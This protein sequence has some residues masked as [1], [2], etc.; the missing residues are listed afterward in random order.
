MEI[1]RTEL[2]ALLL[3]EWGYE[4]REVNRIIEKLLKMETAILSAFEKWLGDKEFMEMPDFHGFNPKNLSQTYPL[5][6]PAV[7]LMLDWIRRAP[8]EATQALFQEYRR[9]PVTNKKT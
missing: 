5:K 7:F 9:L 4:E 3:T 2:R 8:S 6:P 1:N